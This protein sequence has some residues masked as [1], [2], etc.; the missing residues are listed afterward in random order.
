MKKIIMLLIIICSYWSKSE[1]QYVWYFGQGAGIKF[2]ATGGL[3]IAYTSP[4]TSGNPIKTSE[5][6]AVAYDASGNVIISTD[7]TTV[8]D[9]TNTVMLNGAG[10]S[11]N[12]SS[13]QSGIIVPVPGCECSKYFVF[14]TFG[15]SNGLNYSLVDMALNSGKGAVVSSQ[16]NIPLIKNSLPYGNRFYG[17]ASEKL[18]SCNDGTGGFW[19]LAHGEDTRF[20]AFHITSSTIGN[21][22]SPKVDTSESNCIITNI[23]ENYYSTQGAWGQMKFSP[24]GTKVGCALYASQNIETFDFNLTTGVLSNNNVISLDRHPYGIE[25]SPNEK[26]LYVAQSY[27]GN[28]SDD[29]NIFQYD[30]GSSNIGTSKIAIASNKPDTFRNTNNYIY[31]SMQLWKDG[32]IYVANVGAKAIGVINNPNLAGSLS[33]YL[34]KAIPLGSTVDSKLSLPTF[35]QDFSNCADPCNKCH[36]VGFFLGKFYTMRKDT[37]IKIG[38][39]QSIDFNPN[40]GCSSEQVPVLGVTVKDNANNTPTWANTFITSKGSGNFSP[41]SVANTYTVTYY[42]GTTNT[43]NNRKDTCDKI[44]ITIQ[45]TCVVPPPACRCNNW[46]SSVSYALGEKQGQFKC[47]SGEIIQAEQGQIFTPYIGYSCLG[48]ASE[49]DC[50]ATIKYNIYYPNG[51]K[52]LNQ[53]N[54]RGFKLDSCG[55]NKIVMIP[56]CGGVEC[57]PCEFSINVNCCKC[58]QTIS[59]I[60]YT[61]T[62]D[63]DKP[64][65]TT[66]ECGQ[67]YTDKLE[68]YKSNNIYVTNPCGPNCQPD[69]VITT[70]LLPNGVTMLGNSLIANQV[71][72]YTV[73]I[74][75]KCNGKWCTQCIIKFKQ[76]KNC[77]PPCDNCKVNGKDKVDFSFDSGLSSLD[78]QSL[79]ASTTLNATFVLGGGADTYTQLRANVVDFQITSDNPDCLACYNKPNQWGSI[80]GGSVPSFLPTITT[81]PAVSATNDYNSSREIIFNSA[82]PTAVPMGTNLNLAIKV[83]G[84][85]TISCCCIKVALFIKI[86]YRNNKCEECTKIVRVGFTQC[87]KTNTD[88]AT[89]DGGTKFDTDGGIPVYRMHSPNKDDI[90]TSQ[91][92]K[93]ANYTGH[94]TLLR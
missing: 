20:F 50:R 12:P 52:L 87:P 51:G 78:V 31:G 29:K 65:T 14:T 6:C 80:V 81:Y 86:T 10:L 32:R 69:E 40:Y 8:Y 64:K 43:T 17:N 2:P 36:N 83:P 48:G 53:T 45:D 55:I 90:K 38:C 22:S 35:I 73:T 4:L 9:K 92:A 47:N 28:S 13:T 59:P 74:K 3:P 30:L 62:N 82:T 91:S 1:A 72:T 42:F 77:E 70:I 15:D 49:G 60:L 25:F 37:T 33:N 66:L 63:P 68:C 41:P 34:H 44:I 57:Q 58:P 19:V 23:G 89:G 56:T 26:Y 24:S 21:C 46:A 79:P 85:N 39:S 18:T 75:A 5:G 67:T 61:E 54:L 7:G 76:T 71:G 16:K 88:P 11:G 27:D 94:V 93:K 84:V